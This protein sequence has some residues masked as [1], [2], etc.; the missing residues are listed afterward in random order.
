MTKIVGSQL[1]SFEHL[2]DDAVDF[3]DGED[4]VDLAASYGLV[5]DDWQA[6][7]VRWWLSRTE[8]GDISS[9]TNGASV[10]RQNGKNGAIEALELYEMVV[11]GR[12]ILHTAHEVKTA[13]KA[14]K[15]LLGFFEDP[16]FP[17]LQ[18][19][20]TEVRRTNGQEALYLSTGGGVEFIARSKGSGRGFTVD[21]LVLDEAQELSDDA[22]EAL[23]PTISSAPSG[24][25]RRVIVGTPPKP[26]NNGEVFQRVHDGAHDGT[27]T[28]TVWMEWSADEDDP[29]DEP[30]TWAVA[31]PALG[32]RLALDT[33]KD[34]YQGFAR[35]SF[36]RERLGIW[37]LTESEA[38]VLDPED[39]D[40]C[41]RE[42]INHDGGEIAL[43]IDIAPSR[44]QAS[45]V[46]SGKDI[47]GKA[48][49]D[50]I[51]SRVGSIEWIVPMVKKIVRE[52]PVRAVV[53]DSGSPAGTIIDQLTREGISVTPI[54]TALVIQAVGAFYDSVVNG[55]LLHIGQSQLN[56]AALSA[57]RRKIGQSWGWARPQDGTDI[58][59]LVGATLARFGLDWTKANRPAK[60][61][62]R[63]RRKVA[64][65]T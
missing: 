48:W 10:P 7:M 64:M 11:L 19:L 57:G 23:Q 38:S 52:K 43:G 29:A 59:T 63:R 31:N 14:F 20:V 50:V 8:D 1:P 28:R 37:D 41:F 36:Q 9:T 39:W 58:T 24:E 42:T 27:S 3:L 25:P 4:A 16:E 44:K 13:R 2:P 18:E 51:E 65:Y 30:T 62:P 53:V 15:R 21:T 60:K 34:E 56:S 49:V 61:K 17:D 22:L 5:L 26:I 47:D 6:H 46:A 55:S 40:N 45:L 33:V 35:A 12:K 32:I 54:G